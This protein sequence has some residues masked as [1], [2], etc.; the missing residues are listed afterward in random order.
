ML[1]PSLERGAIRS[2]R[3]NLSSRH[4]LLAQVSPKSQRFRRS[5]PGLPQLLKGP[6]W[7]GHSEDRS[8]QHREAAHP[9]GAAERLRLAEAF[10]QAASTGKQVHRPVERYTCFNDLD[11]AFRLSALAPRRVSDQVQVDAEAPQLALQLFREGPPQQAGQAG[12]AALTQH[13]LG[14]APAS[15]HLHEGGE[16]RPALRTQKLTAQI[17]AELFA[18]FHPQALIAA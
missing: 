16:Q 7:R 4:R 5:A 9:A 8:S 6:R 1:T 11:G 18:L 15:G 3:I 12:G 13:D 2:R 17:S 10:V 14:D